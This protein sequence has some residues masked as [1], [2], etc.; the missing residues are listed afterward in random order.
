MAFVLRTGTF[1]G[2]IGIAFGF[3]VP[4]FAAA[5]E[6]AAFPKGN[7]L[8]PTANAPAT[9]AT[10]AKP[11][12]D[13]ARGPTLAPPRRA[14]QEP[15][16]KTRSATDTVDGAEIKRDTRVSESGGEPQPR[17]LRAISEDGE[18]NQE[19]A[20]MARPSEAEETHHEGADGTS[21]KS[22][23]AK[24]PSQPPALEPIP[25]ESATT[26]IET[27]SFNQVTPGISTLDDVKRLWGVAKEVRKQNGLM[28]YRY[29]IEP[30]DHVEVMFYEG[31]LTSIVVRLNGTFEADTVAAQLS[32]STIRPVLISNE[33]GEI[34]GQAYPE[35]GV[36]FSFAP[37]SQPGK[38]STR[39]A[40]IILEPVSA[41]PFM[42]RAETALENHPEASLADLEVA[43]K[44]APDNGRI[45]WLQARAFLLLGEAKKALAA[46]EE[47]LQREPNSPYYLLTQAQ[48]L[49]QLG[50]YREATQAAE[51][52]VAQSESKPHL[53]VR[54][55]C[56]LGDLASSGPQPD[57]KRA[58]QHHS[59]A[60]K[61]AEALTRDPHPAIRQPAKEVLVDAHL[62]A[63][64]DIAWGVWN[65]KE[66]AVAAWL[67]RAS[68]FAE[69]L[70]EHEGGSVEFRFR[71]ATRALAACVGL[72]GKLDPTPWAEQVARIGEELAR[73]AVS[74]AQK[75]QRQ[76]ESGLALY[77]AVQAFQ[78]RNDRE[79]A[80][81]FGKRAAEFFEATR[82]GKDRPADLYLL[83]RLYFRLGAV[84]ASG[85]S[86]HQAALEWFDKAAS[87][88]QQAAPYVASTERGRLG[89]TFVSMGVS[90]WEANQRDKAVEITRQ[91]V[92][93]M[94][95]AVQDGSLAKSSLDIA[96][97]NLATMHRQLG[98][99]DLARRY[100]EK[101]S[102][103]S[104]ATQR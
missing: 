78:M 91:G 68:E 28:V 33:L 7:S 16:A 24:S 80:D 82:P 3:T 2:W 32:L 94:E 17:Q 63:A 74:P 103:K 92:E 90:Y 59:Q 50:R 27:A 11:S 54:A 45:R 73:I 19:E 44:M 43:A 12:A 1:G 62:G 81:K 30:F 95:K 46:V 65:N 23:G 34:L 47:A 102:S 58:M 53:K 70:I 21:G 10:G 42:L 48:I 15:A 69:D 96:Y 89:E 39:V 71:V 20:S 77:D 18:N 9:L 88:L 37:S 5:A 22:S 14:S 35:R 64:Q 85:E 86:N 29:V 87:T 100:A 83:G 25:E 55:V 76:R 104:D 13:Q 51:A 84:R 97:S 67:K 49:G 36:M 31:K 41:E 93:I 72:Q 56:L 101:V 75:L 79:A 98:Q 6:E 40:Q 38:P 26:E 66:V 60:V 61:M 52:A 4:F 99:N 57:Y 8:R